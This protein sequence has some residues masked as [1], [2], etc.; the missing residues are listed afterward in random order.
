MVRKTTLSASSELLRPDPKRYTTVPRTR[1]AGLSF[2]NS[3][4]IVIL[5]SSVFAPQCGKCGGRT[6]RCPFAE[7]EA[8]RQR[9]LARMRLAC[10]LPS[11]AMFPSCTCRPNA[12][13]PDR[14]QDN[15]VFALRVPGRPVFA[16]RVG[17]DVLPR[18]SPGIFLNSGS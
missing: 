9:R 1:S 6:H 13:P 10:F 16:A 2:M 4:R 3:S 17:V 7:V 5:Y 14:Q 8:E 15:P 11:L 18:N 12:A